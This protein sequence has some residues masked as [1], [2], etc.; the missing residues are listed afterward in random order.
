[1][2]QALELTSV[3]QL[4]AETAEELRRARKAIFTLAREK[5]EA[6]ELYR[7]ELAKEIARLRFEKVQATLIPDLARG[8]E[9]IAHLKLKRD[10]AVDRHKNGIEA[11]RGLQSELSAYQTICRY[12]EDI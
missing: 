4:M 10:F 3:I 12:Q 9:K 1:M 8:E 2:G 6:E 5:G 7:V 11:I